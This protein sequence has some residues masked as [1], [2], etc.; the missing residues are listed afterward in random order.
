VSAHSFVSKSIP[1]AGG[2]VERVWFGSVVRRAAVAG[3]GTFLA[4]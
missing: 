4:V 3:A 1:I 2:I